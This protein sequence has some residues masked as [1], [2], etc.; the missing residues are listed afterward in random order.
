LK[1]CL[2]SFLVILLFASLGRAEDAERF[3]RLGEELICTCSCQQSLYGCRM[4]GCSFRPPMQAELQKMIDEGR[5][6]EQI[7]TAFVAKYGAIV[8]SAPTMHGFDI[9]AWLMPFVALIAGALFVIFVVHKWRGHAVTAPTT[10]PVDTK[11]QD[12]VE[13]ELQKFT[14]ED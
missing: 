3:K 11:F 8:L 1:L 2:N 13:E 12:R 4:L 6:D 14:P 7:R 9:T 10:G 5:T